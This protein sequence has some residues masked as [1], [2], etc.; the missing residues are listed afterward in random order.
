MNA[1][2]VK[3]L[4]VPLLLFFFGTSALGQSPYP[5]TTDRDLSWLVAD[6]RQSGSPLPTHDGLATLWTARL[7]SSV[8]EISGNGQNTWGTGN[9]GPSKASSVSTG[10]NPAA[11]DLHV[12]SGWL[13]DQLG[14][15]RNGF[16]LGGISIF[17]VNSQPTGGV[18]PGSWTTNSLSILD[19]SLDMEEWMGCRGGE[20]GVEFLYYTGGNV[21]GDAGT[22]MGYN[23]LDGAPPRSRFEIYTMWY[24]QMLFDETVTI[25]IGKLVPIYDF[26]NVAR[27]TPHSEDNYGIPAVSSAIFTPLYISPTQ[28][29]VM[30]GYYNSAT[31]VT[32]SFCPN[33][34]AYAQYGL[35]DGSLAAG[36]QTG[37]QG[38]HFDGYQMHVVEGGTVWT[39]GPQ[40]K[41]GKFGAGYWKQTGL[42]DAPG[43]TVNGAD[44]M[45]VFASQR[46][47]YERPFESSNG[48][49]TWAQFSATDSDFIETHRFFGT[50]LTYFGPID[51]RD[52]DSAGFAFAYG[53]MNT[54]P[55]ANLGRQ[56]SIYTW[57]YQYQLSPNCYLQPNVTYISTPAS[58]PGLDDV[59]ALTLQAMVLF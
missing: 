39:L 13:G 19:M 7:D 30:P 6:D 48:L 32:A 10:G 26:N 44:G 49:F 42:L 53:K 27:T 51:G 21:N 50:G 9:N 47:Y 46:L 59:L 28:L 31:G 5:A 22:V 29:G 25:R 35:Y 57:Y 52:N 24:R 41:P 38:P 20:F 8:V 16:R 36:R 23:S 37:L 43:G 15:N 2:L 34:R 12:G 55:A 40:E 17:D 33:E 58:R 4:L 1:G 18:N 45:Y 54:D 3:S 11:T 56:E 14:V